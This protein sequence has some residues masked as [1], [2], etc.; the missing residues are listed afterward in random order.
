MRESPGRPK[1][2]R[3]LRGVAIGLGALILGAGLAFSRIPGGPAVLFSDDRPTCEDP[4]PWDEARQAAGGTAAVAGPVA[5]A[6]YEPDVEGEPTFVNLG[7]AYPEPER[8]DVVIFPDVRDQWEAPPE[9]AVSGERVCVRGLVNVRDG[10]AQIV[11]EAR[12]DLVILPEK[13][14]AP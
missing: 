14:E 3:V 9:E 8:F 7:R 6:T 1:L 5:H 2:V 4:T 10:V 12:E 13:D 11:L